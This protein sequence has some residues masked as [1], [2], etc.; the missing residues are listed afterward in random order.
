MTRGKALVGV[1][2]SLSMSEHVRIELGIKDT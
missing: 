1:E 2:I